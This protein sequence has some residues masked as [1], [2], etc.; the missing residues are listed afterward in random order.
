MIPHRTPF[1]LPALFPSLLWKVETSARE[2]FLTFDDGPVP[3]PTEFVLETLAKSEVKATFFCIGDNVRKHGD[4]FSTLLENGHQIGNH[5]FHHVSGWKT[6]EA[7][8]IDEIDRCENEFRRH[9]LNENESPRLFRP[10]YGRI[11]RHQIKVLEANYKIVMWDV[12]SFDYSRT[13][14][15]ESCLKNTLRAIRPGSIIVFHDSL[16]AE[17]NMTYVLPRFLESCMA[18]GY[19]FNII[20]S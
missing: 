7:R 11:S 8:Y 14:S 9:G 6:N 12:L 15:R 10:P 17:R 18:Q 4:I 3:G 2:L 1:F 13:L 19:S 16:K 5:T 20:P